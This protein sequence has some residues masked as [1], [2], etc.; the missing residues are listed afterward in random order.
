[1][2]LKNVLSTVNQIEKSKFL[3][4]LDKV[5]SEAAGRDNEISKKIKNIDGQV[6]NA[7]SGEVTELFKV[8]L[9]YLELSIKEELSLLGA[10]ANLLIN[11]ISRD[12]NCIARIAWVEALYEK[13]WENINTHAQFLK[14]IILSDATDSNLLNQDKK[15]RIY[16][17]CFKEAYFNDEK[18]KREAKISNDERGIL[19]VLAVQLDIANDDKIAIEHLVAPIHKSDV[20]ACLDSLREIGLLF[21]S[22]KHQ[23]VYI[24]DEI[25]SILHNIQNKEVADKYLLRILRTFSDAELSNV[26]KS[27]EKKIRGVERDQKIKMI[28]QMGLSVKKLIEVEMHNQDF[29]INERKERLKKLIEDLDIQAERIGSTLD[30]RSS[31]ILETLKNSS[32][33]EFNSLSA[34]GYK[35]MYNCLQELLPNLVSVIKTDFEL[36][37]TQELDVEKLRSLGITPHDILYLINNNEIKDIRDKLNIS[38]R[39]NTRLLILENFA[40]ATDKLIENYELLATRDFIKLKENDV[41][42]TEAEIGVKFEEATKVILEQLGLTVDE[43]LRRASNSAKD[44]A[45]I[46]ISLTDEDIIIGEAKTLKN[47]EFAKYSTTSRQIKSYVTRY[48]SIGKRVTQVL[49]IAPSFSSDFIESAEMDTEVNISL[50]EAKGL[51]KIFEAYNSKRNPKFSAKLLTKGGLLKADLIAKNI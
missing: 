16:Y 10:Q 25:V 21:V 29:N 40:G 48:E 44:R 14:P 38:P 20:L 45:D 24:P 6:K 2:K 51:K 42:V 15:L 33:I 23:T 43:D 19:N 50:L 26:L 22:R 1:M 17:E 35:E 31:I 3:N 28:I 8:V 47:G 34:A 11:I 39:G 27:H 13:E 9:P 12:G 41:A 32:D 37:E 46:V 36:E 18:L 5:C 7:S 4:F 30:E 49:I